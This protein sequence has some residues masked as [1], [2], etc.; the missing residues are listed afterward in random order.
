MAR[1]PTCHRRLAAG[2]LCPR[3]GAAASGGTGFE[4][5]AAPVVEGFAIEGVLGSGGFA[6][7]WAARARDG[8]AAAVKVSRTPSRAA[9]ARLD[10]EAAALRQVG[11]PVV[12]EVLARSETADGL[13][14]MAMERI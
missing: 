3:D 10:R 5:G 1:C 7:T 4:V 11:P 12:P 14:F 9:A 2:A 13:P 6:T 8:R